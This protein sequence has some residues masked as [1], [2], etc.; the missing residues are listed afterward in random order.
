MKLLQRYNDPIYQHRID[1]KRETS[2]PISLL[3]VFLL[4]VCP[5][6]TIS[7]WDKTGLNFLTLNM[8]FFS[9]AIT[10]GSEDLFFS[11][12]VSESA[13]RTTTGFLSILYRDE[14]YLKYV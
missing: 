7:C 3:N 14:M 11:P 1:L 10:T 2:V 9:A 4:F 6:S 8:A 5:W 13:H 12:I